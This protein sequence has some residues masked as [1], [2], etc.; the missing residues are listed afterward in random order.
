MMY[1]FKRKLFSD[2][3]TTVY[4]YIIATPKGFFGYDNDPAYPETIITPAQKAYS[5]KT[6]EE[7]H[8]YANGWAKGMFEQYAV[9]KR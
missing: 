8:K 9:F 7:A 2:E 5:F 4:E 3:T 6:A 1:V